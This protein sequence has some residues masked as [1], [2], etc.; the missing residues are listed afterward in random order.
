MQILEELIGKEVVDN[1]GNVMGIVKDIEWDS[2]VNRVESLVVEERGSGL[3]SLIGSKPRQMVPYENI[4]SIG[5]KVLVNI[6][7]TAPEKEEEEDTLGLG[8]FN[9]RI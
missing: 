8:R 2:E 1:S 3:S 7:F 9:L 5:D 6:K 4:F